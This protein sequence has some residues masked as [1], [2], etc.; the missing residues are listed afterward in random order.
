MAGCLHAG[1]LSRLALAI[2]ETSTINLAKR[3]AKRRAGGQLIGLLWVAKPRPQTGVGMFGPQQTQHLRAN[4]LS[5]V[6]FSHWEGFIA[7]V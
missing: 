2:F 5:I 6:R 1:V 3:A 7:S 4:R